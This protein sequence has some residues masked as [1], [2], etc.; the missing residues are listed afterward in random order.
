MISPGSRSSPL[1]LAAERSPLIDTVVLPD[2]RSAAFFA[3]GRARVERRPVLVIATSGTAPANWFGAVIEASMDAVPLVLVS[4]DRPPELLRTGANQTID[5]DRMFGGYPRDFLQLPVPETA[6]LS[7]FES[8]ARRAAERARWP[9]PGPV[10]VNAAFREPLLP[11]SGD[12]QLDWP[13]AVGEAPSR[14]EVRM[15]EEAASRL[16]ERVG[17]RPGVIVCGRGDYPPAFGDR[18]A[19]LATRLE[20]PVI[21]DPLSGL[22][23]GR[24][25]RDRVLTTADLMLQDGS[26]G[27]DAEWAIQFG[28]APTSRSV[29][30]WVASLGERLVLVDAFGDWPD[31][32]HGTRQMLRSDPLAAVA[33]LLD[34]D[35]APAHAGWIRA[36]QDREAACTQLC[37]AADCRPPEADLIRSLEDG[38]PGDARLFVGNSMPV[39]SLD[40]FA[41]GREEPLETFGN[42]GASGIDGC[43]ST[44]AGLAASGGATVGLIGDLALYHDMNGL[45]AARQTP[46]TL[47]VVNNGGGAIFGLLPQHDRPEFERLWMTPTGLDLRR[48]ADLYDIPHSVAEP[49]DSLR[50]ALQAGDPAECR[51]I[52]VRIDARESW[53]RHRGLREAA[54]DL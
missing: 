52:E 11:E 12:P 13:D 16:A 9:R 25:D 46:A 38:L 22:R 36:W 8:S 14:P 27:A 5:Q 50:A 51:L 33:R 15:T 35:L 21:A 47:V 48:V 53:A 39:R 42:R 17:G 34:V 3:L 2:E 32:A 20:S 44:V 7:F 29:Q 26:F 40:A 43:V 49:G 10:H 28:A 4:A 19:S 45:L 24:H 18:L 6:S 54:G 41:R 31:P 23:W 1:A 37:E 30:A